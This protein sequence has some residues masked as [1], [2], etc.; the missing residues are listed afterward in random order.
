MANITATLVKELREK[1]G[2]GMMECKKAL[3]ESNGDFD[4]AIEI[5]RKKGQVIANK[6]AG[7]NATEGIVLAKVSS[8]NT[9]GYITSLN[10]ETDFV[11]KNDDFKQLAQQIMDKAIESDISSLEQLK[12]TELNGKKISD[13]II[14]KT[15]VIGEK[16]DLSYFK[17]IESKYVIAYIHAGN[18]LATLVGFNEV[19][20]DIQV[21]KDVAMQVAAMDPIALDKDGISKDIID[22]EIEISKEQLRNEGKPEE[23]LDK[24]AM[25]KLNKYFKENTLLNQTFVKD[26]KKDIKT[27]LKE[28]GDITIKDFIRYEIS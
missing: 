1:S 18:K 26:N 4:G 27:L 2:A 12:E 3:T 25:G 5:I 24:I 17:R 22:K 13:L 10:C 23:M 20:S 16:L 21:G 28:K 15:G 9:K 11:A 7:R 8:D 14:E 19:L 6:R